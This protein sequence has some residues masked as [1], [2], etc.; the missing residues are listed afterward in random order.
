MFNCFDYYYFV[1]YLQRGYHPDLPSYISVRV[2]KEITRPQRCVDSVAYNHAKACSMP[3]RQYVSLDT[4]LNGR[5]GRTP[6]AVS[7]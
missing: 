2:E 6:V 5:Y 1:I 4:F 7:Y 3:V